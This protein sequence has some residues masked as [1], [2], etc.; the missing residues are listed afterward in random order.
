MSGPLL[1]RIDLHVD[2]PAVPHAD[3]LQDAQAEPSAAIRERVTRAREI[4]STRF[5]RSK[6]FCNAKMSSRLLRTHCRIDDPSRRL[7][8]SAI[9]KLGL[10]ARAY[11]R[12]LKIAR[13]IADLE[14]SADISANHIS[15]A[16]Q[17]RTLDRG[18][19]A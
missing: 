5:A 17:Y 16:I 4:Q 13:T 12:I 10:S 11:N 19:A 18:R 3:L 8:E 6:I 1:D 15:E 2:V 7:L 14:G 9:E